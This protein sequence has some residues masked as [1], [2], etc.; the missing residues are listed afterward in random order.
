[1]NFTGTFKS[2][3]LTPTLFSVL[4]TVRQWEVSSENAVDD[5]LYYEAWSEFCFIPFF[6][7]V[8]ITGLLIR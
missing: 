3:V 5:D 2:F 8:V 1:M 6:A 7:I 4:C